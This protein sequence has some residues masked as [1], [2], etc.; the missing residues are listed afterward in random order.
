M[1]NES[2]TNVGARSRPH[3][4]CPND[5]HQHAAGRHDQRGDG[6]FGDRAYEEVDDEDQGG[7]QGDV[8]AADGPGYHPER[9]LR[10][11]R[12][13]HKCTTGRFAIPEYCK[14]SRKP[15]S[16]TRNRPCAACRSVSAVRQA[17]PAG[18]RTRSS[19][20]SA[21]SVKREQG[22]GAAEE[23]E[24]R[25]PDTGS[26]VRVRRGPREAT[27]ANWSGGKSALSFSRTS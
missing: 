9:A 22:Q 16:P 2:V 25:R 12:L 11:Q 24:P 3:G 8:M 13:S 1:P 23:H 4:G 5:G 27:M 17:P 14:R 20:P 19:G 10:R 26:R 7:R 18:R 21:S 6:D 15:R